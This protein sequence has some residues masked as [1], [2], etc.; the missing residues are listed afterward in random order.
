MSCGFWIFE[1]KVLDSQN[2][3]LGIK[4]EGGFSNNFGYCVPVP[5]LPGS[6]GQLLGTQSQQPTQWPKFMWEKLANANYAGS[7]A[8]VGC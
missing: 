1:I 7:L 8:L 4:F 6:E 5:T 3:S 2:T